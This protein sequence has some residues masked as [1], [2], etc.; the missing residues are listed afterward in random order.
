ML[1]SILADKGR[2]WMVGRDL[3]LITANYYTQSDYQENSEEFR[4]PDQIS[5]FLME[6]NDENSRNKIMFI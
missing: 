2:H 1:K 5:K 3:L 4:N 6:T